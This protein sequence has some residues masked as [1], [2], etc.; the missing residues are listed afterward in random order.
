MKHALLVASAAALAFTAASAVAKPG[1]GHGDHAKHAK[2][3]KHVDHR[4]MG[5]SGYGVGN[6]PPGLAKKGCMPPGQA[7]KLARGQRYVSSYGYDRYAYNRLPYDLRRQYDLDADDRYY[8][9]DGYLYQ[10][11]PRTLIVQQVIS[12]LLR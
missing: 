5:H 6:C 10:V 11:D 8:Y 3:G 2:H 9:N 4:A 7:K 12:A 1:N